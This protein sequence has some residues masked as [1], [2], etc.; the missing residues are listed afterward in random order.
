MFSDQFSSGELIPTWPAGT[1]TTQ[2]QLYGKMWTI[3]LIQ[4]NTGKPLP[5]SSY[6]ELQDTYN[7]ANAI[8]K[9]I[10]YAKDRDSWIWWNA[11]LRTVSYYL[12]LAKP[13]QPQWWDTLEGIIAMRDKKIEDLKNEKLAELKIAL[14]HPGITPAMADQMTKWTMDTIERNTK[15]IQDQFQKLIDNW[16]ATHK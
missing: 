16:H 12:N 6:A 10:S 8:L 1:K 15:I 13:A 7:W 14:Q 4:L 2:V 9:G 5:Y 3:P 11:Y